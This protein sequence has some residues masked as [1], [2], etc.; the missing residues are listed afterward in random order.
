MALPIDCA[1]ES[2]LRD[3]LSS[4]VVAFALVVETPSVAAD[5]ERQTRDPTRFCHCC[6]ILLRCPH[7]PFVFAKDVKSEA[8][9]LVLLDPV[10]SSGNTSAKLLVVVPNIALA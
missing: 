10:S 9:L 3:A 2:H 8:S 4:K 1:R 7:F 5:I 6:S